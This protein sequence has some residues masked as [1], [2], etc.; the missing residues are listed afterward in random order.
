MAGEY[1]LR[2][3]LHG[4]LVSGG[5]VVLVVVAIWG[6]KSLNLGGGLALKTSPFSRAPDGEIHWK[7]SVSCTR[8]GRE[9]KKRRAE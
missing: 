8:N 1:V 3:S 7:V 2:V 6:P 9:R 5:V 4:G